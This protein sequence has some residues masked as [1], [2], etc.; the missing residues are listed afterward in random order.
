[1]PFNSKKVEQIV[2]SR[3]IKAKEFFAICYPDRSG[4]ASFPDIA[5]NTNPKADTV[6][7]IADLLGCSID[8]LFDRD[9]THT[10][11][12]VNGDNNMVGNVSINASPDVL[13]ETNKHL[14]EIISRQDETIAEQ[15]RRIDQLIELARR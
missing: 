14:R 2:R 7:R 4:N 6:E 12:H 11:N 3:G 1:M 15:N 5:K 9:I 10:T 8:D 13:I